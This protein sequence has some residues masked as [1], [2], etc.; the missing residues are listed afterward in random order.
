MSARTAT[1]A[2]SLVAFGLTGAAD[3]NP[4]TGR[5]ATPTDQPHRWPVE[6]SGNS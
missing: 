1:I 3:H 4:A 2:L 6:H 5:G